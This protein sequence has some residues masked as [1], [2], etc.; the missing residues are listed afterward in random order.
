M[1]DRK[2]IYF[3]GEPSPR[4][5]DEDVYLNNYDL[6]GFKVGDQAYQSVEHYFQSEK[7]RGYP[8]ANAEEIRKAVIDAIDADTSKKLARTY[9]DS[10]KQ[11]S[12]NADHW[13]KWEERKDQV[14]RDAIEYKFAQNEELRKKL[15]ETG[16]AVLIEDSPVDKYWGGAVEGSLNKLGNMLMEYREKARKEQA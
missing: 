8:N 6:S 16:D 12:L 5:R 10:D 4:V 1:E 13:H 7:Y 9:Q 3:Y 15:I 14:M 11:Q 2:I